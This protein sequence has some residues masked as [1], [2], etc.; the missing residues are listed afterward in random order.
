MGIVVLSPLR[1]GELDQV[2]LKAVFFDAGNTLIYPYP[3]VGEIYSRIASRHGMS[4]DKDE[5]RA[6]FKR[7]FLSRRGWPLDDHKIE[8]DWW[9]GIVWDA[10]TSLC[11]PKNFDAYFEEL[12]DFFTTAE[13]WKIYPEVIPTLE[14]LK[15]KGLELGVISNWDSRLLPLLNNLK[16]AHFFS[17]I[18]VSALVG[19]VKP[20]RGIFRYALGK[21]G[22]EPEES[23]HVGDNLDLDFKGARAGGLHAL[24]LDR[25]HDGPGKG[26]IPTIASIDE[27]L[28]Y[29]E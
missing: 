29:T 10:V 13:A 17:V 5:A 25:N 27:V 3:S 12:F 9:K 18:A 15:T 21:V 23:L 16:L 1:E 28:A 14:R 20:D 6:A 11:R 8:I 2:V 19:S 26:E 4:F 24:L 22:V 7:A